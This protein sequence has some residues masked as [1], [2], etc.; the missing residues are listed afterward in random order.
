[1]G[2]ASEGLQFGIVGLLLVV[3]PVGFDLSIDVLE[4]G[5]HVDDARLQVDRAGSIYVAQNQPVVLLPL[6]FKLH[7]KH[8]LFMRNAAVAVL[9]QHLFNP[10]YYLLRKTKLCEFRVYLGS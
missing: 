8:E 10:I 5:L 1:M 6:R 9:V 3:V 2:L 7:Y 4:L